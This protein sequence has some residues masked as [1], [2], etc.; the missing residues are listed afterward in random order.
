MQYGRE[1]DRIPALEMST[2]GGNRVKVSG[3]IDRVDLLEDGSA[4]A[5]DYRM[6]TGPINASTAYHGINLRLL[7]NLLVLEHCGKHLGKKRKLSPAGTFCVQLLRPVKSG[8]PSDAPGPGDEEFHL[9]TKPRG[10]FD[11]RVARELDRE[12]TE[13]YSKVV[14]LYLKRDG[15]V[16]HANSTDAATSEEFAALLQHVEHRIGEIADEII[17]GRIEIRPY[18]MGTDTPCPNCEFRDLCR[19]EPSPGCYD[20]VEAMGRPEMLRRMLEEQGG[21]R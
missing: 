21:K 2:P 12:L 3:K 16:G 4:C 5:I 7:V 19:L 14:Q 20:D 15:G 9:K 17:G 8:D 10:I 1:K 6:W 11:L 13:G 18:R